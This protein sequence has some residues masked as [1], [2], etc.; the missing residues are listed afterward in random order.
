MSALCHEPTY[1]MQQ[2]GVSFD[3]LVGAREQR[4]ILRCALRSYYVFG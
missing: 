3:H 4:R 1:A 2:A